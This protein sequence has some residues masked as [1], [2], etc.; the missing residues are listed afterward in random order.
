MPQ[1]LLFKNEENHR[2]HLCK[3]YFQ[4]GKKEYCMMCQGVDK[5]EK[6]RGEK[7]DEGLF[8]NVEWIMYEGHKAIKR[9]ISNFFCLNCY[10]KKLEYMKSNPDLAN[11]EVLQ[12]IV[13]EGDEELRNWDKRKEIIR[14]IVYFLE[15]KKLDKYFSK[16]SE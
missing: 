12:K 2:L 6:H 14:K 3:A 9:E 11:S 8:F 13:K 10:P 16:L 7:K 4:N 1:Y 5:L 15:L